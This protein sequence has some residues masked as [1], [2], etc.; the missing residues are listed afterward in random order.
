VGRAGGERV[1]T[2]VFAVGAR[3]N[4]VKMA[5][6]VSALDREAGMRRLVVHTG[7]HYDERMSREILGDLEFPAPDHFLEVG[8]G[9]HGEQT[10]NALIRFERVLRSELP[11]LVVVGGD[12][13]STLACAL[14]AAKLGIPVAH[15]ESGLRSFDW[16]MPE[17]INRVLTDRLS[18]LLF[19]HSPEAALNLETEGIPSERVHYVGNTMIDTLRRFEPAAEQARAW[20]RRGLQRAEY[21]LVTLHRP[22]NVDAPERLDA[23][24]DALVDLAARTPVL[25]PIHPRTAARLVATG[26]MPRLLAAGVTC[27]E[28]LGYIDFLSAQ[29]GS[30]A[31]VTD[32][33][34]IQEEAAALGVPCFTLRANTE[35]PITL[36]LGTNV[37]LGDDPAAIVGIPL[38]VGPREACTIPL[39]DGHAGA[40]TAEVIVAALASVEPRDARVV[41]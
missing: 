11:D 26:G 7:Q 40:R 37:L 36:E 34:G 31:I 10:G 27:T 30:T 5:P 6:V 16:T 41:A 3:P 35:R 14:G 4:F 29:I 33:G 18:Q 8:S 12:V 15:V 21:V 24:V 1:K 13:N 23:V 38:A 28:P 17:E 39:W 25:F 2:V 20:E 22:S 9:T 32:S 19:T